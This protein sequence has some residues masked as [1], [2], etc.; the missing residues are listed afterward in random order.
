MKTFIRALTAAL[1]PISCKTVE[2]PYFDGRKTAALLPLIAV[3]I[4]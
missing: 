4:D 3:L 1:L 2:P